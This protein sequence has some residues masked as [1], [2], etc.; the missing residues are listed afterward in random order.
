LSARQVQ[1]P[2]RHTGGVLPSPLSSNRTLHLADSQ[3]G[4]YLFG[5][6]IS[7]RIWAI[8]YE[9]S[10]IAI[11]GA[12]DVTDLFNPV[13]PMT[14]QRMI[15]GLSSFGEDGFGGIYLVDLGG[16]TIYAMV[17]EPETWAM[18]LVMLVPAILVARRR[19]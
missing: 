18:L 11:T 1:S 14:G 9:G 15:T 17:P 13:D 7:D 10:F 4:A 16:G 8:R 19:G 5:D 12:M 6:Y 2:Q 3:E